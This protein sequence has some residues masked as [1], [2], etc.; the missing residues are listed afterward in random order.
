MVKM[1]VRKK[2]IVHVAKRVVPVV[3]VSALAVT[4]AHAEAP[5]VTEV[6]SSLD[7]LKV[8]IA[9]VGGAYVALKVFQRGWKIIRGFI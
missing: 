2:Q 8:P 1:S 6:V 5:N 7:G 3:A 9:S 4:G